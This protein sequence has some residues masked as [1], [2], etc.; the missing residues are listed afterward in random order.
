VTH[1]YIIALRDKHIAH[2]V[3]PFEENDIAVQIADYFVSSIEI[4]SV[5]TAHGKAIGLSFEKPS[6]LRTLADW[7]LGCAKQ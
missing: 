4:T 3:N 5:N 6:Q 7:W 2:S 1:E